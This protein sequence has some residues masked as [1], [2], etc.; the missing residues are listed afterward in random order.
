[1]FEYVFESFC[2]VPVEVRTGLGLHG[3][4]DIPWVPPALHGLVLPMRALLCADAECQCRSTVPASS[5]TVTSSGVRTR[6]ARSRAPIAA[7]AS[8]VIA[9]SSLR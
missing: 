2:K 7:G 8:L 1:M 6:H 4:L 9:A 3:A 5:G